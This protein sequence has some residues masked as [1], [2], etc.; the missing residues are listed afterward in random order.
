MLIYSIKKIF[1]QLV[2]NSTFFYFI[3]FMTVLFFFR[4]YQLN[5]LFPYICVH[6]LLRLLLPCLSFSSFI[7][8]ILSFLSLLFCFF[9]SI[10]ELFLYTILCSPT[11]YIAFYSLS[12]F[13]FLY[14]A[15]P[16]Y[17]FCTSNSLSVQFPKPP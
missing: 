17:L 7:L 9:G 8:L 2:M 14:S 6:R 16:V 15:S 10:L 12:S 4:F 1:T 3:I 13:D 11:K 5:H